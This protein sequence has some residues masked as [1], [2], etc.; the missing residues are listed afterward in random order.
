MFIPF[1]LLGA[2]VYSSRALSVC[3]SSTMALVLDFDGTITVEDTINELAQSAIRIHNE[4]GRD[5]SGAWEEIVDLH[6]KSYAEFKAEYPVAEDSRVDLE[7]ERKY[8]ADLRDVEVASV[9]RIEASGLFDG[10]S[11]QDVLAAGKAAVREGRI[12][13]R[14]GLPEL[15]SVAETRGW[16]VYVLSVNWSKSFIRGV[17]HQFDDRL[18]V[19]SNEVHEGGKIS[20]PDT[21]TF[22]ATAGDKL[23]GL[24]TILRDVGDGPVVYFGDSTTDIE[25]L[26]LSSGVVMSSSSG[27]SLLKTLSRVGVAVP[28][29]ADATTTNKL[30]WARDF[31][32]VLRA[33][34][35]SSLPPISPTARINRSL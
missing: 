24:W 8:L 27:S 11:S 12:A 34:T 3:P 19:V 10:I 35:L 1:L 16:P 23:V 32:E 5:F 22:L 21:Q 6:G 31:S 15:L 29:V 7:A 20:C 2:L 9:R 25:C 28:H 4:R 26:L 33:G 30:A 14:E 13:L 17:L 18:R